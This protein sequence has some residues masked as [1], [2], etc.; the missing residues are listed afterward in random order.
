[1][2]DKDIGSPAL[3]ISPYH[4]RINKGYFLSVKSTVFRESSDIF[5]DFLG[6]Y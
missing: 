1:M 6:E 3:F 5:P 2:K 4:K